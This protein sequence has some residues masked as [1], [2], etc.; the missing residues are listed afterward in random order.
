MRAARAKV[1]AALFEYRKQL[2]EEA[3]RTGLPVVRHPFIQYPGDPGVWGITYQEFMLGPDFLI[4][5]VT[6]AGAKRVKV[7][8]PCGE[9]VHLWSGRT[10]MGCQQITVDA[11]IG[12]PAVFYVKGSRWGED[13]VRRL[14]EEG[15]MP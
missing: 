2:I 4:A 1:Y 8:L 14:Q 3:S 5:P 12:Q 13:L 7:Y 10:Y 15:L 9:W 6:E 11:P